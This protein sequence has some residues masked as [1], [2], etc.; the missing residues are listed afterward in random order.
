MCCTTY[1]HTSNVIVTPKL[2][3][4]MHTLRSLGESSLLRPGRGVVD[5]E[6]SY[7]FKLLIDTL[8]PD[9]IIDHR[10]GE[11]K[12][13]PGKL[14]VSCLNT[15]QG[16]FPRVW[17]AIDFVTLSATPTLE[18]PPGSATTTTTTTTTFYYCYYYLP[19]F[20]LEHLR[21]IPPSWL[22]EERPTTALG[23]RRGQEAE[24]VGRNNPGLPV[25]LGLSSQHVHACLVCRQNHLYNYERSEFLFSDGWLE[26]GLVSSDGSRARFSM[27]AAFPTSRRSNLPNITPISYH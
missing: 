26:R 12:S 27:R 9:I 3:E 22:A 20:Q 25:R 16:L 17:Y 1:R 6:P 24:E 8:L 15:H 5:D 10:K 18:T 21:N 19:V 7:R 2:A 23:P 4:P 13:K 14:Q 11:C